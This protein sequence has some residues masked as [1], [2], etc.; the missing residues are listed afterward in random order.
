MEKKPK[1]PEFY[2]GVFTVDQTVADVRKR[3]IEQMGTS[4]L[5]IEQIDEAMEKYRSI[6][7]MVADGSTD[8]ESLVLRKPDP[9]YQKY[10]KERPN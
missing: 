8:K 10:A 9:K 4:G 2:K 3:M 1:I 5:S 6:A 7:Q